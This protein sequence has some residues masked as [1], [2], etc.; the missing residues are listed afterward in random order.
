MKKNIV[1]TAAGTLLSALL[2]TSASFVSMHA[3]INRQKK[4][5]PAQQTKS[6]TAPDTAASKTTTTKAV[7]QDKQKGPATKKAGKTSKKRVSRKKS[8]RARK[9][10]GTKSPST[11]K[12]R[13]PL[14]K[15]H[16]KN[17]KH[18]P[19][20]RTTQTKSYVAGNKKRG[21]A[22]LLPKKQAPT[23]QPSKAITPSSGAR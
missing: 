6:A 20:K 18:T 4:D 3:V 11:A 17:V 5:I 15:T 23:T 19:A 7:P 2:L 10:R 9:A 8:S 22:S 16:S 21:P 1:T 13:H 12:G 14:S